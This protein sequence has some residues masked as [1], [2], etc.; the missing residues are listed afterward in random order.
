[1]K[2]L[3]IFSPSQNVYSETFIRAHKKLPLNIKYYYDGFLPTKLEETK[4]LYKINLWEKLK[5]R[6]NRKFSLPEYALFKSLKKEKVDCVLAEYGPTGVHSL[7][8]IKALSLPL[9]VHFFG[10]DATQHSTIKQYKEKYNYVF[11]YANYVVVVSTKMKED[12]IKLGCPLQKIVLTYCGPDSS[13]FKAIP[14]FNS[15]Q[16]VSIGR[17]VDKK[18]PYLTLAA[19]KNVVV[20]FPGA[21]LVMIGDGILLNTCKNLAKLWKIEKNVDFIG[22]KN[23]SEIFKIFEDSIAFVQHSITA[24]NGDSEG[25]PVAV[26]DAQAAGI[27]VISTRHAGITEVIT[28]N[29]TGFLVQEY[30]VNGMTLNMLRILEEKGVA[31]KMGDAGRKKVK[32]NFSI[33]KN[34]NELETIIRNCIS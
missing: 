19:F 6:I 23:P 25:T 12:L 32:D 20:K 8:V 13:F 4:S 2:T 7:N 22:I 24:D 9:V 28:D 1:M 5:L 29:V 21:R 10:Y 15:S 33:D 16:F 34:L 11:D 18:A 3:A 27:P 26:L 30:D 14:H 31:K 17:F